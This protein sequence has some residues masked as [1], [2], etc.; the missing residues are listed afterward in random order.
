MLAGPQLLQT[1]DFPL[2]C[3][4]LPFPPQPFQGLPGFDRGRGRL[5]DGG[6][7]RDELGFPCI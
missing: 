6:D 2:E 7:T 5:F 4:A 3:R 1:I